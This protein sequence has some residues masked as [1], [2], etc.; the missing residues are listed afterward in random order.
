MRSTRATIK[1]LN[2]NGLLY[3]IINSWLD[4]T[5]SNSP[6]YD[7]SGSSSKDHSQSSSNIFK[8]ASRQ[9]FVNAKF[10][11]LWLLVPEEAISPCLRDFY[12]YLSPQGSWLH[13]ESCIPWDIRE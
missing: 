4:H 12:R 6:Y 9:S 13:G 10:I 7:D 2:A 3:D 5:E 8:E 11:L 1:T